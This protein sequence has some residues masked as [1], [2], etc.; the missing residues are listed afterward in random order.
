MNFDCVFP[1]ISQTG[2]SLSNSS[3]SEGAS[4]RS[5]F[6]Q[7]PALTHW[8]PAES[9]GNKHLFQIIKD[10][11]THH[12]IFNAHGYPWKMKTLQREDV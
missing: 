9:N 4:H 7:N 5:L 6:A 2:R 8:F 1:G 12:L 11:I 10:N 3:S